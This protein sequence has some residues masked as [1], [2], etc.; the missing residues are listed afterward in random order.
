MS[1]FPTLAEPEALGRSAEH[2]I[3]EALRAGARHAL[4]YP[5]SETVV[6]AIVA[7]QLEELADSSATAAMAYLAAVRLGPDLAGYLHTRV[8]GSGVDDAE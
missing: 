5:V 7:A 4:E 6:E 2:R 8:R 3:R 1:F